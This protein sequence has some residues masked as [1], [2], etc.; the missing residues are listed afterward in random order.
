MLCW[1]P[2]PCHQLPSW[3][4]AHP[5]RPRS[6]GKRFDPS[7]PLSTLEEN[8]TSSS[9]FGRNLNHWT[10]DSSIEMSSLR[11]QN[12]C[13][14]M[15]KST[16][17]AA[18]ARSKKRLSVLRRSKGLKQTQ[19]NGT[20]NPTSGLPPKILLLIHWSLCMRA[21]L[22]FRQKIARKSGGDHWPSMKASTNFTV[23]QPVETTRFS[24]PSP[25]YPTSSFPLPQLLHRRPPEKWM[26][27]S[28][29]LSYW[30]G[31]F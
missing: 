19:W 10:N 6:F 15:F 29:Y 12:R 7:S 26:V 11:K 1:Q 17:S 25:S 16:R 20:I 18:A 9:R 24:P 22:F 30:G 3:L 23:S 14:S 13:W 21:A 28:Y 27:G 8:G 2:W 5:C 4:Q 31:L